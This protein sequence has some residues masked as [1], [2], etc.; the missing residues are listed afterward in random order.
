MD[1]LLKNGWVI[2]PDHLDA[3][4]DIY[5]HNGRIHNV[6]P[7]IDLDT[8][9]L[10]HQVEEKNLKIIDLEDKIVSPGF[11]DMHVHFREP[12]QEHKETILSG[13][14]AAVH[15]GITGVCCM[16]NTSPVNDTPAITTQILKAARKAK[17]TRVFPCAAISQSLLGQHLSPIK[18]LKN[19][20]AVALSDDGMPVTNNDLMQK[21][22]EI[23]KDLDMAVIS[24][25]EN[26]ELAAGGVM[27]AGRVAKQLGLPGISNE[28]ESVM[29]QRDID[30]AASTKSRVHIAHVSTGE[31]VA[32][33]R[34]AKQNGVAVTAETAPHYFTLTHDA[35][36]KWGTNAKMNPPLRSS[37]DRTAII[38]GLVDGTLDAIATDHAPHS[39]KEKQVAFEQAPNGI[40]GLETSVS[41]G[42]KLVEEGHLTLTGFINKMSINPSKILGIPCGIKVGNTAD[43]TVI[44]LHKPVY[45]KANTF[46][47]KSRNT[48]FDG[49]HLQGA[50]VMTIVNGN[51]VY[52][53]LI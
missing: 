32:A 33:I 26:L 47:S 48:P 25:A 52:Q 10:N 44:D 7:A 17:L 6:Q 16:P 14:R 27:N 13:S 20:G 51:I 23:A 46:Q 3:K 12:G 34:K 45:V 19:A 4:M 53:S 9:S 18:A 24:H 2:D 50:V 43:I 49:C 39:E 40:I 41:L 15:G 38:D 21:A 30:L 28:S 36:L 8:P 11:V 37:R 29:V 5:I 35:V 31:S 42:L 22:L 1:L